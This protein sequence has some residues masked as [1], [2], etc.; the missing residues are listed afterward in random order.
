M[1][2]EQTEFLQHLDYSDG[3]HAC[4]VPFQ[5]WDQIGDASFLKQLTRS[6][7]QVQEE[8]KIYFLSQGM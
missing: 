2:G 5:N 3:T 8:N 6:S 4:P 1:T 7:S